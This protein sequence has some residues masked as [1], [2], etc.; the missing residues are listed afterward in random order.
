MTE[1]VTEDNFLIVGD[2]LSKSLI[3]FET[4]AT[5]F[6]FVIEIAIVTKL[7]TKPKNSWK[8]TVL[9]SSVNILFS[10]VV[11][12]RWPAIRKEGTDFFNLRY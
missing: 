5:V 9:P 7:N 12:R 2:L 1:P 8:K 11:K 10:L 4:I 6:Y 3:S